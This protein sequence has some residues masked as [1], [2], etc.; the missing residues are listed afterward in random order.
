MH[1]MRIYVL[2]CVR[3]YNLCSLLVLLSNP[4][5]LDWEWNTTTSC[6]ARPVVQAGASL[7]TL[8]PSLST[9][10][11]PCL[12]DGQRVRVF[13]SNFEHLSVRGAGQLGSLE[14]EWR[15]QE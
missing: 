1:I 8:R 14:G 15:R 2:Y 13:A 6:S 5:G 9:E 10:F 7:A 4:L 3:L 12:R 11:C